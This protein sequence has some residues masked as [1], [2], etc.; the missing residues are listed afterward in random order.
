MPP[1]LND[2]SVSQIEVEKPQRVVSWAGW[3]VCWLGRHLLVFSAFVFL[4]A[5]SRGGD[6]FYT[7]QSS[8]LQG[9]LTFLYWP[10]SNVQNPIR[11][12]GG[13]KKAG[14]WVVVQRNVCID[15]G[16]FRHR[17]A[18]IPHLS[19]MQFFFLASGAAATR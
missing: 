6:G 9:Q 7:G 11:C 4:T 5:A 15:M 1:A 8:N 18:K 17:V 19:R 14:G 16:H 10:V 13:G 12:G 3:L 2:R